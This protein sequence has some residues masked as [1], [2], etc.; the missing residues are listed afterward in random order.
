MRK[1]KQAGG[2]SKPARAKSPT[3]TIAE[4]PED[5]ILA[6]RKQLQRVIAK[7]A[8]AYLQGLLTC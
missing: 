6:R 5:A 4:C 7:I 3:K 1:N 2:S 8:E